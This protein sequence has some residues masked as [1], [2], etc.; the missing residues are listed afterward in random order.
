MSLYFLGEFICCLIAIINLLHVITSQGILSVGQL[1]QQDANE[2]ITAAFNIP[3]TT[4]IL[5]FV[6]AMVYFHLA[7][8]LLVLSKTCTSQPAVSIAVKTSKL[9]EHT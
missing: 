2:N 9:G 5:Y 1:K 4:F 6:I 7:G 8:V 3:G